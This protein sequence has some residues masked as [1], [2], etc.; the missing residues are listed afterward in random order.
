MKQMQ[1]EVKGIIGLFFSW[2][3]A[4]AGLVTID[5]LPIALSCAAS[6]MTFVYYYRKNKKL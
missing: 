2:Y 1:Q 3:T 6:I 5:K 4:F